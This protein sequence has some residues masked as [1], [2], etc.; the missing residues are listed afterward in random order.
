MNVSI[1]RVHENPARGIVPGLQVAGVL[2]LLLDCPMDGMGR[3]VVGVNLPDVYEE[4]MDLVGEIL[5]QL[6]D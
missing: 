2:E 5:C 3:V 1:Q 6:V 4:K